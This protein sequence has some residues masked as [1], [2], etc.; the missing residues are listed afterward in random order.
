MKQT[1]RRAGDFVFRYGGEEF[2]V[3]CSG[4][5]DAHAADFAEQLRIGVETL[6][7][8]H[9]DSPI[10]RISVSVGYRH[11]DSLDALTP[12]RL[13]D[14]ADKALYLAKANGRNQ[15]ERYISAGAG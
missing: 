8:E 9:H 1:A 13:I 14:Q 5:D 15:I 7:S 3:I 2:C 4:L 10:G 11:A 12:D 6:D